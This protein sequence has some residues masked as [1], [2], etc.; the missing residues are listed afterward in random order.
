MKNRN[1]K[2]QLKPCQEHILTFVVFKN[3]RQYGK[4]IAQS[5]LL[6]DR[7]N[8]KIKNNRNAIIKAKLVVC[9]LK[10]EIPSNKEVLFYTIPSHMETTNQFCANFNIR[11]PNALLRLMLQMP[12][13]LRQWLKRSI[14]SCVK[15]K[16]WK[17][18]W[19]FRYHL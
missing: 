18:S 13:Y 2:R 7:Q 5:N 14:R 8:L 1:N 12:N 16:H 15:Q 11:V 6:H 4:A 10:I 9:N 19:A 17:S 3:I